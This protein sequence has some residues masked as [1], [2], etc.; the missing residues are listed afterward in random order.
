M[1]T[2]MHH[3]FGSGLSGLGSD[4]FPYFSTG[5]A[6]AAS[7]TFTGLAGVGLVFNS[8]SSFFGAGFK[9]GVPSGADGAAGSAGLSNHTTLRAQ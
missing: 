4:L 7:P 9:V 6:D 1:M 2:I 8:S 5:R 3:L